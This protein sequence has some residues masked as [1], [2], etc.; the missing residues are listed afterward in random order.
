MELLSGIID[1]IP[2][3]TFNTVSMEEKGSIVLATVRIT[4]MHTGTL[5]IPSLG[6]HSDA[7]WERFTL[8]EEIFEC[9]VHTNKIHTIKASPAPGSG[10]QGL[11]QRLGVT[12]PEKVAV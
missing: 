8:P 4:G 7:S 1:A 3:W 5:K 9:S 10:F 12:L 2:N 6:I 11:L